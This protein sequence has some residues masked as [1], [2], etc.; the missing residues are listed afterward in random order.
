M[1][2]VESAMTKTSVNS[3]IESLSLSRTHYTIVMTAALGFMFDSFDTYI[4][5]YA[6]P[7]IIKEWNI[8]PVRDAS[9]KGAAAA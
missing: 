9:N 7:S 6:M 2:C 8:S 4:V 1:Q 3:V 5:A